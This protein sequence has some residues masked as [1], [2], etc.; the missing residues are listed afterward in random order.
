M[1]Q[2]VIIP[3]IV[4]KFTGGAYIYYKLTIRDEKLFIS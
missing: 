3:S 2:K 1:L 4:L